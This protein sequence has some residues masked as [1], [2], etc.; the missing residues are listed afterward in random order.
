MQQHPVI[1]YEMVK[2]RIGSAAAQVV[3]NHHQRFNGGGYPKRCDS[4]T[5][6]PLPPMTGLQIP[7]FCR[8]ATICDVYDAA[9][10]QR[11]YSDAKLPVQVLHELKTWCSG[12]FDP[13]IEKAFYEIIPAFPIG[14]VVKLSN[15]FEAAV[16]DFNPRHS[17]RPKVQGL[18]DPHGVPFKH[19]SLEEIDL[20]M[21]TDV[22]IVAV[23]DVDVRP[24]VATLE[25]RSSE[26]DAVVV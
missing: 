15:G 8:I 20:A 16:V 11:V 25:N 26:S 24:F 23:D 10:S 7:V 1:G 21:Y 4:R 18:R 19:P 2:G 13:V 5:G 22:E 14:Q 6:E 17:T 3:L 9:T 12:F